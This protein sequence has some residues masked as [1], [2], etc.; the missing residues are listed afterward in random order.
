MSSQLYQLEASLDCSQITVVAT[1]H[2][3]T[4]MAWEDTPNGRRPGT[5]PDVD[6][7]SGAPFQ[8]ADVLMP[9]G[10]DGKPELFSVRFASHEVPDLAPYSP[11]EIVGLRVRV[12]RPKEG[13]GVEVTFSA[14]MVR[15]AG[16]PQ[17]QTR[18]QVEGEAA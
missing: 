17:R 6:P 8:V 7:E 16:A 4:V 1:G 14:D 5:T 9:F 3:A 11:V 13:K 15:P 12:K 10:R 2:V 18:R